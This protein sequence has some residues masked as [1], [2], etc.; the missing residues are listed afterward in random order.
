VTTIV[1]VDGNA[2]FPAESLTPAMFSPSSPPHGLRLKGEAHYYERG[3]RGDS[4]QRQRRLV[5]SAN[6]KAAAAE[7][8]GRVAF[9]WKG[10]QVFV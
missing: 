6:S 4:G 9:L 2:Y 7:I 10:V 3:G 5:L 1:K 8:K